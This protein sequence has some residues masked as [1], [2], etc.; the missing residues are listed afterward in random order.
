MFL[1]SLAWSIALALSVPWWL[2]KMATTGKYR[3]GLGERLGRVPSRLQ[4]AGT[5]RPAVWIHAVSVGEVLAISRLLH[6]LSERLPQYRVMVSTTT[7]TG[8]QIAREQFGAENVFFYPLDFAFGVRAYLRAIRPSVFVLAETEFWPRMLAECR[9]AGVPVAVVNA[10]ISNRSLPRY[11]RLRRLWRYFLR[12]L[13]LVLAQS[14][15]DVR[16]LVAIGVAEDKVERG[17]NLKYDVRAASS[18][19]LTG[20]VR[21]A[22]GGDGARLLVCGSTLHGEEE[23]LLRIWP[24]L[25]SAEPELRMV[26]A[27]RHPERF[28]TVAGLLDRSGV[29][30]VRRSTWLGGERLAFES[31]SV[32]LLDSIGE[33]ASL[34]SLARVAFVGG[35][36]VAAGGHNPLEPAQFGVPV[37]MGRHVDNFRDIVGKLTQRNAVQLVGEDELAGALLRLLSDPALAKEIGARGKSVFEEEAGAT[38]RAVAAITGLLGARQTA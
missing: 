7:R 26:L 3:E 15:E 9:V 28:A 38:A 16:R 31:G 19:P 22:L 14:E 23:A 6:E 36:L 33:L 21:E 32:L 13:S 30:W 25:V 8:Q 17:G 35:S 34:F 27:P 4:L 2:W 20:V 12:P 1:Y 29:K 5:R 11:L 37:V 18:N 10:R 24:L